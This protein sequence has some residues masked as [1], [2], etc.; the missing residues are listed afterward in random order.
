MLELLNDSPLMIT[1]DQVLAV[2]YFHD[3]LKFVKFVREKPL[4]RTATGNVALKELE[5]LSKIF[6]QG[7]QLIFLDEGF[8]W[9]VRSEMDC[10]YLHQMRVTAEVM[11]LI[12]KRR[13][14]FRLSK[15][16]L[17]YL[18]KIE[19]AN[20][21]QAMV[22]S[23]WNQVNW[24]YF[25]PDQITKALQHNQTFIW[26]NLLRA[27]NDWLEFKPFCQALKISLNLERFYQKE[28]L[29][30]DF[31]LYL[32]IRHGLLKRLQLFGCIETE[33]KKGERDWQDELA[34]FRPTNLG[35]Y[36]FEVGLKPF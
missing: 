17:G 29:D 24:N 5:A 26:Q 13:G 7:K 34:R 21:Y 23:F 16:G 15:N 36:M 8:G 32:E 20:Q 14:E 18:T 12:Y 10:Q 4:T 9:K 25:N 27:G 31:M 35:L 33:I 2:D 3:F 11:N 22:L 6:R 19:P 1:N 28:E 30:P